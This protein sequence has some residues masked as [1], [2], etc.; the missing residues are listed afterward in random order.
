MQYINGN[1]S[2]LYISKDLVKI[3]YSILL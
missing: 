2:H 1:N 3:L